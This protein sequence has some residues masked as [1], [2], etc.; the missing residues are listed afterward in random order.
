MM[1]MYFMGIQKKTLALKFVR[2]IYRS[3]KWLIVSKL[4]Y[5]KYLQALQNG[6]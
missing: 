4:A 5:N 6:G 2:Y 1:T 3:T